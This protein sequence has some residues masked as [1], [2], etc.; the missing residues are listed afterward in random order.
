MSAIAL[1]SITSVA[2]AQ[3]MHHKSFIKR[4]P[5]ASSMMA[6]M[7]AHHYARRHGHGFMHRHPMATGMAAAAL[8]H[9]H[10]KKP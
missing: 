2:P 8:M 1:L 7:A 5:M 3:T 6:G 10:A 9:H 4:H